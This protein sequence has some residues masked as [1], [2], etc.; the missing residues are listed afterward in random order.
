MNSRLHVI[1][2]MLAASSL[3]PQ[4]KDHAGKFQAVQRIFNARCI[5]CHGGEEPAA[6]MSLEAGSSYKNLVNVASSERPDLPR[7][8]PNDSKKSY[9]FRKITRD[10]KNLPFEEDPMPLDAGP[11]PAEEMAAIEA[12]INSFSEELWGSGSSGGAQSRQESGDATSETFLATQLINLPTTRTY[13]AR[14]A[15]FRILH[16]FYQMNGGGDNTL[17]S[18]FGLDN[19]AI[20]SLN[21]G[22]SITPD[23]D[24]LIRRTG[25]DKDIEIG[26]KYVPF[27]QSRSF[28]L[29]VGLYVSLDWISRRDVNARNK[30]APN[31][32]LLLARRAGPVS[33]L[34]VPSIAFRSNHET[35]LSDNRETTA[36][37]LG[38][39][40]EVRPNTAIT[41]EYIP[42][43]GGYRG[44]A[45]SLDPRFNAWSFGIMYKLGLHV[46]Q[47]LLSNTQMLHTT[48][49]IPGSSEIGVNRLFDHGPNFHFGFNIIRQFKW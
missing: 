3:H 4:D 46:F 24:I 23:V 28:P 33:F 8:N 22:V 18:F 41:S 44:N 35:G 21:L 37:G 36:L 9:L 12:W 27:R 34:A 6:Q 7:I 26:A 38:I 11:L 15:E 32:Q 49:Y 10:K 47:V 19:G 30:T 5:H 40:Y 25:S 1:I 17:G 43:I 29:D 31:V 45:S 48:Q 20:T 2:C 42:R 14:T 16:R 39:Q 13:G